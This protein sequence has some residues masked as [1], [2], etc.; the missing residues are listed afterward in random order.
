MEVSSQVW[1]SKENRFPSSLVASDRP[2]PLLRVLHRPGS[3]FPGRDSRS[4]L[5]REHPPPAV[6]RQAPARAG[7]LLPEAQPPP[8]GRPAR[9][10]PLALVQ[11]AERES[12]A[13]RAQ[14]PRGEGQLHV[15]GVRRGGHRRGAVG[16]PAHQARQPGAAGDARLDGAGQGTERQVRTEGAQEVDFERVH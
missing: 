4:R 16:L 14:G 1:G 15:G 3:N 2:Q 10:A 6:H 8:A 12:A 5:P 9:A 11:H 13:Q 7:H